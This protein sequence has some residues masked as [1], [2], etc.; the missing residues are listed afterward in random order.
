MG[1]AT[2]Q[3]VI[4]RNVVAK[5]SRKNPYVG[6]SA[7]IVSGLE[8]GTYNVTVSI[9]GKGGASLSLRIEHCDDPTD[10]QTGGLC[11]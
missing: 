1:A 11:A 9:T 4:T 3:D 7:F 6:L 10:P 2:L 8:A 5:F